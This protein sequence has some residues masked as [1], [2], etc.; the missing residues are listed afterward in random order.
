MKTKI[1]HIHTLPESYTTTVLLRCPA[2]H[3]FLPK[4][5]H[6]TNPA[7][8]PQNRLGCHHPEIDHFQTPNQPAHRPLRALPI[9]S[10]AIRRPIVSLALAVTSASPASPRLASAPRSSQQ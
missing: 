5:H 2:A 4:N 1:G 10:R 8:H 6:T 3:P 7:L 9:P